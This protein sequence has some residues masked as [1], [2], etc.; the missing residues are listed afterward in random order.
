MDPAQM[1]RWR[2]LPGEEGS[3]ATLANI[4]LAKVDRRR[5]DLGEELQCFGHGQYRQTDSPEDAEGK[6]VSGFDAV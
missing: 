4:P 3:A 6:V 5:V 2:E 1:P